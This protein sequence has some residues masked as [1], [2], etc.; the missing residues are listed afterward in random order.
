ML[1][2]AASLMAVVLGNFLYALTVKLFLLPSGLVTGGTTGIALTVNHLWGMSISAFVL[3]FNV[4]MLLL[5]WWILGKAFAATTLASTFL[6]PAFLEL[7]DCLLGE[8]VITGDLLLCTVFSGLG[9]GISLGIVIRA[10]A[11]TGGMD[12]P[13]LVLQKLFRVPVPVSMYAFDFA[14]L[15]MQALFR[16]AENILYG[17]LLVLI[18]T[19]VLD[20]M[21]LLGQSRTEVKIVSEQSGQICEA[22]IKQI[23]RG[24]TLLEGEGGYLHGKTQV[25]LSVISNRELLKVE[26]IVRQIDPVCFMVVSRVSEVRGRGF[27]MNKQYR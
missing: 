21:L 3:I 5:G 9:I 17:I 10:G 12:I 15:L 22:I 14:I 26:R 23:D 25:V 8:L 6:Y 19:M 24:V 18:Y 27:S 20:K 1:R 4:G 2:T 13:P 11:S 7:C 16:P